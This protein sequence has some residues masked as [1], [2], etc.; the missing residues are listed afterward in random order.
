MVALRFW[1]RGFGRTAAVRV[2]YSLLI[3]WLSN[4]RHI[5]SFIF[6]LNTAHAVIALTLR[7][8]G[9]IWIG[10]ATRRWGSLSFLCFRLVVL[11]CSHCIGIEA[12]RRGQ[13]NSASMLDTALLDEFF[14]QLNFIAHGVVLLIEHN[15]VIPMVVL[16]LLLHDLSLSNLLLLFFCLLLI[17]FLVEEL[18]AS[19]E[20]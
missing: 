10:A 16:V 8:W 19:Q 18:D 2:R 6:A 9:P 14:P 20:S 7:T 13:I 5:R 4:S 17:E 11:Y 1:L 3:Y 12:V 15:P